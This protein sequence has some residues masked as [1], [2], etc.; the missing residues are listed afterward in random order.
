M[1]LYDG[2]L[3]TTGNC[4]RFDC[5]FSP[6]LNLTTSINRNSLLRRDSINENAFSVAT[7]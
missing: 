4:D 5:H 1:A 2:R 7:Y 6:L 3:H